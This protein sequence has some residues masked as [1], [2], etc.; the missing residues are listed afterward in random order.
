MTTQHQARWDA[1][2]AAHPYP[3]QLR[4]NQKAAMFRYLWNHPS[5]N[6]GDYQQAVIDWQC[7][8]LKQPRMPAKTSKTQSGASK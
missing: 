7:E 5:Q 4:F 3:R 2:A 6:V 8:V 1:F